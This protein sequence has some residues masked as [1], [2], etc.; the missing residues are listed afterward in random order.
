M[1]SP[2]TSRTGRAGQPLLLLGVLVMVLA[3][4][5]GTASA[6]TA[7]PA[8]DGPGS[9]V[10]LLKWCWTHRDAQRYRDLFTADYQFVPGDPDLPWNRDDE[11]AMVSSLFG[12]GTAT[13]PGAVSVSLDF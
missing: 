3:L 13:Q 2:L 12:S 1:S 6:D 5:V 8:P 7:P 11:L 4:C 10:A 9:V